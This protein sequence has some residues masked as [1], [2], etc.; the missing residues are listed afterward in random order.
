MTGQVAAGDTGGPTPTRRRRW[1][2]LLLV[3]LGLVV[4][5]FSLVSARNLLAAPLDA[6]RE[7]LAQTVF[8]MVV[9]L[10]LLIG[11]IYGLRR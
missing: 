5:G 1:G 2:S 10:W 3:I 7:Y 4:L 9:G 6:Q 8:P 11:G